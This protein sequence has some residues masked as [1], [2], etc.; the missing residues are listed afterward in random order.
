MKQKKE[1]MKVKIDKENAPKGESYEYM[2]AAALERDNAYQSESEPEKEPAPA[3]PCLEQDEEE[4]LPE[5]IDEQH[6]Q[7]G[8]SCPKTNH[9]NDVPTLQQ[10]IEEDK[11][12]PKGQCIDKDPRNGTFGKRKTK[13]IHR[14]KSKRLWYYC[15]N[16]CVARPVKRK[17]ID[18]TPKAQAALDEEWNRLKS[19]G[20]WN[21][22]GVR[23]W[24]EV[25]EEARQA[26]KKIHVAD[27]FEICVQ[28]NAELPDDD[29]RKKFKGR[30]VY[31]G[32]EGR[33]EFHDHAIYQEMSSQPAS[34]QAGKACD[35]YGMQV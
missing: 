31:R 12:H 3:M 1:G 10:M 20:T 24:N 25:A 8:A 33:D 7:P 9:K 21:E 27:I 13:Q 32:N 26:N 35:A 14:E 29:P 5:W 6:H 2:A 23:E 19:I 17:E 34:M 16:A 22:D 18:E 11:N 28:K 4:P 15:Y 30:S